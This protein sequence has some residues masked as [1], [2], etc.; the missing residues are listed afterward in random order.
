MLVRDLLDVKAICEA[1]SFRKAAES[2]RVTQPTL[3][4][5][6]AHLEDKLGARLFDR[7]GGGSRPTAL[8]ELIARR[9]AVIGRDAT[10]LSRDIARLASGQSGLVRIGAGPAPGRAL[11]GQ[12]VD[13]VAERSPG[14]SLEL[15]VGSTRQLA[16]QL[17]DREIDIAVCHPMEDAA[18]P[19][20][21][22][23][24]LE[25]D[26][27]IVAH[28]DHAMFKGPPPSISEVFRYR[29]AIPFLEN[30]YR[31]ILIADYG[32]DIEQAAG[33]VVCSDFDLLVRLVTNST[34]FFTAGPMFS[35]APEIAT[36]KLR[37][38]DTALP[39]KHRVAMHTNGDA[40][41]L[42]AV[43]KVQEIIRVVFDTVVAR[44]N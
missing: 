14:L 24:Q 22:E 27:V 6:I 30:R 2:L 19:I 18:R 13:R 29:I 26:N 7:S 11:L 35:F 20:V 12:V 43:T 4:N 36:G 3:S 17:I 33:R 39:F 40:Y 8:A 28:P 44:R 10:L 9:A 1:G 15:F 31:Q 32:I 42:P 37:V 25:V 5:R 41:P 34:Q 23:Q 38:L 21:L 16:E